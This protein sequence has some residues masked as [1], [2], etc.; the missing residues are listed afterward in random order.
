MSSREKKLRERD[1]KLQ[2]DPLKKEGIVGTFCRVYGIR[3]AIS[4]FLSD[5]Y[6]PSASEGR[7][8]YIPGEGSCG[9][10]VY[11]D[12]FAYSHHATDP[13][14]ER[15]LNAF[16]LVRMHRFRDEDAKTSFLKMAEFAQEDPLVKEEL[17]KERLEQ[18]KKD[19]EEIEKGWEEP[20]PF[21]RHTMMP[22]P[23]DALPEEIRNYASAVSESIQTPVDMAGCAALCVI[24]TSIQGKYRIRGK[25][26]WTEPLNLYVTEIAPP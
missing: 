14:G 25:P 23:L 11:D 4:K 13:A 6:A 3:D 22:F 5:V 16:D 9:V 10:V 15:T 21:G 8:D 18:A 19:F 1:G 20:I 26:D 24:A 12:K 17:E 7:Y 2:E